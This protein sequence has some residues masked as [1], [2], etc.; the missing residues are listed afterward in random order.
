MRPRPLRKILSRCASA[1][2]SLSL[3]LQGRGSLSSATILKHFHA[4]GVLLE[5]FFSLSLPSYFRGSASNTKILISFGNAL[6]FFLS[7]S[8]PLLTGTLLLYDVFQFFLDSFSIERKREKKMCVCVLENVTLGILYTLFD[9]CRDLSFTSEG[10]LLS[11]IEYLLEACLFDEC[12]R[13]IFV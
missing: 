8:L 4:T 13:V 9:D 2:F 1:S 3:S 7:L 12:R 11:I 5:L 10:F 6:C